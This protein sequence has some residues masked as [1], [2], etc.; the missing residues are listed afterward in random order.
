VDFVTDEVVPHAGYV[1][2]DSADI[3]T[4]IEH[5]RPT[6]RRGFPRR[7]V[8]MIVAVAVIVGMPVIVAVRSFDLYAH[9]VTMAVPSRTR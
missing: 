3:V 4:D 7:P 2:D 1:H 6:G 9:D 5:D 8:L